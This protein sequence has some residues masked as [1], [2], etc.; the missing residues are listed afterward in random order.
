MSKPSLKRRFGLYTLI[1]IVIP[2]VFAVILTISR[3]ETFLHDIADRNLETISSLASLNVEYMLEDYAR[4]FDYS[5][6]RLKLRLEKTNSKEEILSLILKFQPYFESFFLLSKDGKLIDVVSKKY[7]SDISQYQNF[8]FSKR[9]CSR[10]A[11]SGSRTT[12]DIVK[13]I[14]T[15][16]PT[17]AYIKRIDDML[18]V[19]HLD[20]V[21]VS[22]S[23]NMIKKR[24]GGEYNIFITDTDGT[25]IFNQGSLKPVL[26][27]ENISSN[28]LIHQALKGNSKKFI[29]YTKDNQ[30]YIGTT[31][32]ISNSHWIL[33]ISIPEDRALFSL[34]VLRENTLLMIAIIALAILIFYIGALKNI[35]KPILIFE[36]KVSKVASGDYSIEL[37]EFRYKE[38]ARL[39]DAFLNM[40]KTIKER[41]ENLERR[42]KNGID[43]IR[44]RDSIIYQN[45]KRKAMQDLLIDLAHHWRQPLNACAIG[46]QN[47]PDVIENKEAVNKKINFS[48]NELTKL[49]QTISR[50][51]NF[52]E[53]GSSE[54]ID[55]TKALELSKELIGETLKSSKI[56]VIIEK[57]DDF[58][59]EM[60]AEYWIEI[61]SGM[62]LN[63]KHI[64][65]KRELE[66]VFVKIVASKKD[67]YEIIIS[68][69]AGGIDESLL[70]NKLFEPYSTTE[71]KSRDKGLGLY[72]VHNI[73]V[74]RLDGTIEAQNSDNGAKFTIRI[75]K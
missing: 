25:L 9:P 63:V 22:K 39:K 45:S 13:S 20:L 51:T 2:T 72:S 5:A 27:R 46:I 52:Y 68:D 17:L 38:T 29:T 71:F 64:A 19:G 34:E 33:A 15:G 66:D 14:F 67:D 56:E 60:Q 41:E 10:V 26:Q 3:T 1:G 47:I 21:S 40:A 36:K 50:L 18:F 30:K 43:E 7:D 24:A 53:K 16:E 8:D 69:N 61:F 31:K 12:T 54:M 49:S 62:M 4:T 58:D 59:L 74:Y 55:I 32:K 48:V 75:P 73:V 11:K 42:V 37:P 44:K 35:I 23:L 70:P 6:Q 28:P 57:D 65:L